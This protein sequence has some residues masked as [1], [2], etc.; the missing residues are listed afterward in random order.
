MKD[1]VKYV[2][3]YQVAPVS[4]VTHIA[5]VQEIRPY[6]DTGKYQLIFKGAPEEIGPIPPGNI[7]SN[8]QSP[9]YVQRNRLLNA[10]TLAEALAQ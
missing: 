6:K 4:A 3:A 10:K 5:E 7:K 1:R 2:A 8:M 9:V